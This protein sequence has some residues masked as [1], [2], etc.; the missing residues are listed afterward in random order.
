MSAFSAPLK[1]GDFIQVDN[2]VYNIKQIIGDWAWGWRGPD[3]P[4][5]LYIPGLV[6][7][8]PGYVDGN[9]CV[10]I[11][12]RL[13]YLEEVNQ[14]ETARKI[15]EEA[16]KAA[17]KAAEKVAFIR[18]MNHL[19]AKQ[20]EENA[21][22]L[23]KILEAK[24][25]TICEGDTVVWE[26]EYYK[27]TKYLIEKDAFVLKNIVTNTIVFVAYAYEL[28]KVKPMYPAG[29]IVRSTNNNW[30]TYEVVSANY[31]SRT[32]NVLAASSGRGYRNVKEE[33]LYK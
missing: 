10:S 28:T 29:T 9:Y 27:V 11:L 22:N 8:F 20:R 17:E 21:R 2:R 31:G 13:K 24:I 14:E 12:T 3:N 30:T 5:S 1:I 33:I 26:H 6:Y 7:S 32:Y 25:A 18:E 19:L 16:R 15:A 23:K 4:I